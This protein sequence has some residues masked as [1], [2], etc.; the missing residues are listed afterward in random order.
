MVIHWVGIGEVKSCGPE[1]QLGSILGSCVSLVLW[2]PERCFAVM[3]HILLPHPGR[4]R[5][6]A[7]PD[8]RFAVDA[9]R[10]MQT[11]L[12]R[13][14]ICLSHCE[15]FLAGGGN[16]VDALRSDI[17][18]Q[19]IESMRALLNAAGVR[20]RAS[21]VGGN[22]HRTAHFSP[23]SGRLQVNGREVPA[24][25]PPNPIKRHTA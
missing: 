5:P 15:A 19:N 21:D 6:V 11:R 24:S 12:A 10:M 17:G 1:A 23:E 4:G 2:Q 16:V 7:H 25:L 8:G 22:R 14:G 20:L 9:W 18:A 3:N 13:Q